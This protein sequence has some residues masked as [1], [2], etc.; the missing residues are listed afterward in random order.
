MNNFVTCLL[1][2]LVYFE[3]NEAQ[4]TVNQVVILNGLPSNSV[5][6]F[7]CRSIDKD[8]GVRELKVTGETYIIEVG[9]PRNKLSW[10]WDCTFQYWPK[11]MKTFTIPVFQYENELSIKEKRT[12]NPRA[13]AIYYMKNDKPPLRWTYP[14]TK[15]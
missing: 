7:H 8:L 5:L 6:K 3:L 11:K 10:N 12:W 14:W 13:D 15:M 4:K 1:I 2:I 9:E